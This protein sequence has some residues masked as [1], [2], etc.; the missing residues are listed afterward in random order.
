M[1]SGDRWCLTKAEASSRSKRIY[2]QAGGTKPWNV[3]EEA[4]GE[5]QG[6][7]VAGGKTESS[8][9]GEG[10]GA[11]LV[12]EQSRG[13]GHTANLRFSLWGPTRD[14]ACLWFSGAWLAL[15]WGWQQARFNAE[16]SLLTWVAHDSYPASEGTNSR[17]HNKEENADDG[18][19]AS[20]KEQRKSLAL[21]Q[22]FCRCKNHLIFSLCLEWIFSGINTINTFKLNV[23]T[24]LNVLINVCTK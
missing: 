9:T 20:G 2:W 21:L 22:L 11:I 12:L 17:I 24:Y 1:A 16:V 3:Q 18:H 5:Q 4:F 10:E 8:G 19:R 13:L 6:T 15:C 23:T 7:L 14:Q